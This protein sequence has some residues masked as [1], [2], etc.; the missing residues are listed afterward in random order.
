MVDVQNGAGPTPISVS[1]SNTPTPPAVNVGT[2]SPQTVQLAGGTGSGLSV[3]TGTNVGATTLSVVQPA[4]FTTPN[5]NISLIG[6]VINPGINVFVDA[7][8][9]SVGYHLQSSASV[10][11]GAVAPQGQVFTITSN[12]PAN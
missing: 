7:N 11:L 2:L 9:G 6:T 5:A 8:S 4:G 3:V 12:D 10:V 1:I